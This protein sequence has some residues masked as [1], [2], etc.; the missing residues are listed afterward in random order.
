MKRA[1]TA[2]VLLAVLFYAET[3]PEGIGFLIEVAD[4]CSIMAIYR[5]REVDACIRIS[6]HIK[7]DTNLDAGLLKMLKEHF[8]DK[9]CALMSGELA[10]AVEDKLKEDELKREGIIPLQH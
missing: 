9:R 8:R 4:R 7:V 5:G 2:T 10:E 6:R 3:K 1:K